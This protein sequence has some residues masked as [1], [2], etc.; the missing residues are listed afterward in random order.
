VVQDVEEEN[1]PRRFPKL[2]MV[3]VGERLPEDQ[4]Q[5]DSEEKEAYLR[6][7]G[8]VGMPP[9]QREAA[10]HPRRTACPT[11]KV[12]EVAGVD[13]E[14]EDERAGNVQKDAGKIQVHLFNT[15]YVYSMQNPPFSN[16]IFS[17]A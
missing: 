12:M 10:R 9:W 13:R 5:S 16:S 7:G 1:Q 2:L 14:G 3:V 17:I 8:T 11:E 15:K 4:A 6:E